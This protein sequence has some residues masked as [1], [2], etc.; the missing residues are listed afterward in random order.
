MSRGPGSIPPVVF[1]WWRLCVRWAPWH[2]RR[3]LQWHSTYEGA[4]QATIYTLAA[5][6][7]IVHWRGSSVR[8]DRTY[9]IGGRD[10]WE[11]FDPDA[12]RKTWREVFQ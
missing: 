8:L 5:S 11:T 6:A 10:R 3:G 7:L 2:W 9:S 12:P 1:A 4:F